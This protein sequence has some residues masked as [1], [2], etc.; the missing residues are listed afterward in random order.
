[1]NYFVYYFDEAREEKAILSQCAQCGTMATNEQVLMN[2]KSLFSFSLVNKSMYEL[3][4]LFTQIFIARRASHR[5]E[6][7]YNEDQRAK[8]VEVCTMNC[9][10]LTVYRKHKIHDEIEKLIH[11]TGDNKAKYISSLNRLK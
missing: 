7:R 10:D 8:M 1:M 5:I 3:I 2:V 11:C 9:P 6:E 4:Q